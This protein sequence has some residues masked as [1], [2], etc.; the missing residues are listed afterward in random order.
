MSSGI[1]V[2]L[3]KVAI[4]HYGTGSINGT[5]IQRA[6]ISRVLRISVNDILSRDGFEKPVGFPDLVSLVLQL[7]NFLKPKDVKLEHPL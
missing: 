2:P 6:V 1:V 7:L 4:L 3:Q 5:T